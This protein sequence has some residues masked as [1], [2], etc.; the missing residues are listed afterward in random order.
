M[1]NKNRKST[2]LQK[3]DSSYFSIMSNCIKKDKILLNSIAYF[4]FANKLTK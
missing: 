4:L 1:F 3:T 2:I